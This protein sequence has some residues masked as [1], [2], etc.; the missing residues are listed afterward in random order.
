MPIMKTP[1]RKGLTMDGC[2]YPYHIKTFTVKEWI[3]TNS[4]VHLTQHLFST[5][6][7]IRIYLILLMNTVSFLEQIQYS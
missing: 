3:A 7:A 2:N 1:L 6:A 4:F 5:L